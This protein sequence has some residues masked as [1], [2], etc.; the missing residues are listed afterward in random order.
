MSR[1]GEASGVAC[2]A[3]LQWLFGGVCV[4]RTIGT[5]GGGEKDRHTLYGGKGKDLAGNK[6]MSMAG[7]VQIFLQP[8]HRHRHR[9]RR[10][11]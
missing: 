11:L 8:P 2:S 9:A 1:E 10:P 4:V 5:L 3:T 7:S 6:K